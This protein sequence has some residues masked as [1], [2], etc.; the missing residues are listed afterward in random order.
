AELAR[1]FSGMPVL[2]I[3]LRTRWILFS[4]T[5]F[6]E[7]SV[8]ARFEPAAIDIDSAPLRRILLHAFP[9]RRILLADKVR[10]DETSGQSLEIQSATAL[11]KRRD[12]LRRV[13]PCRNLHLLIQ[14]C[15]HPLDALPRRA[16]E[17]C[18]AV[19]GDAEA[20]VQQDGEL[21]IAQ[22]LRRRVLQILAENVG[23]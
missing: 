18:D 4:C 15:Q 11:E 14:T 7:R 16:H 5:K 9:Q 1:R 19:V 21:Q 8:G 17:P 22:L 2:G 3:D 13:A 6:L 10:I 12:S 20:D 23:E